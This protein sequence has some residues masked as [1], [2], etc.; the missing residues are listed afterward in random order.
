[1]LTVLYKN[2]SNLICLLDCSLEKYILQETSTMSSS[3]DQVVP[4]EP[5]CKRARTEDWVG[6]LPV[7]DI[8]DLTSSPASVI[9]ITSS[10]DGVIDLNS[11]ESSGT[12]FNYNA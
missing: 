1:M 3:K 6:A 5:C 9:D 11:S 8:I 7:P 12:F 4:N 2:H 10:N